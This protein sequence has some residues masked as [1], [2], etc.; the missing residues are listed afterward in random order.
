[1]G[2]FEISSSPVTVAG[3]IFL[4]GVSEGYFQCKYPVTGMEFRWI[5]CA[6]GIGDQNKTHWN[7]PQCQSI[8]REEWSCNL[9]TP[10][11]N[12]NPK[13]ST[14]LRVTHR[15][16]GNY[17][18]M[19]DSEKAAT[20]PVIFHRNLGRCCC[21]PSALREEIRILG[22]HHQRHGGGGFVDQKRHIY[23]GRRGDPI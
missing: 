14:R 3:A 9:A 21:L 20:R 1:M 15:Q 6:P 18:D 17:E 23:I 13:L 19:V 2:G 16:S 7:V 12:T 22:S 11:S 10:E 5:S 4:S 8:G